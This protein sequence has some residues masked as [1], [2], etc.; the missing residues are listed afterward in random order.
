[1][2]R[3][4]DVWL[5]YRHL[6]SRNTVETTVL[7]G[8]NFEI[9]DGGFCW[10]T[11]PSGAGKTSLLKLIYLAEHPSRGRIDILG[12]HA[13]RISRQDAA[14]LRRRIGVVYQDFRLL[15]HLSAYDNVALPLRLA[16]RS[17]AHIRAD[18][19]EILRWVGLSGR[20]EARP[21]ELSGGEQ[22]RVAIARAVVGR[23]KLLV[24]DE[25]T[26]N[27]DDAQADRL[28]ML[29]TALNQ[30]GTTVIIAT[31]NTGL[32]ERYPASRLEMANGELV[33]YE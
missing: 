12:T 5:R 24:A 8:V 21:D 13:A 7:R 1:M 19:A 16:R 32:V 27:L 31:H 30:L 22:Q 23:P 20:L 3:F 2:V 29:I 18:V 14:L 10:L 4:E 6:A 11:G 17:E 15:G 28:M 33:S 9:P 25:P 26:G